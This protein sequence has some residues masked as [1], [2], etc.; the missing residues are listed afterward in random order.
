[1]NALIADL[2]EIRVELQNKIDDITSESK[3]LLGFYKSANMLST[4]TITTLETSYRSSVNDL[5]VLNKAKKNIQKAI[6]QLIKLT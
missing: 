2:D 5:Y 3:L 4:P 6:K 1:M